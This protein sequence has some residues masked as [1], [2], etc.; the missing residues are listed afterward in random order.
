MAG[1]EPKA[2]R[3][4]SEAG[5]F[6]APA[7]VPQFLPMSRNSVYAAIRTGALPSVRLG[8]L[9]FVPTAGLRALAEE[10]IR[11]AAAV[12]EGALTEPRGA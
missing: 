3:P 12:R 9:I 7:D 1:P 2:L 6:I 11:S 4:L 5:D 8:R 10:A